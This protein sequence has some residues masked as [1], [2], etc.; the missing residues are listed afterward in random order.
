MNNDNSNKY[1]SNKQLVYRS[2]YVYSNNRCCTAIPRPEEN[3]RL[4]RSGRVKPV[5][6]PKTQAA[7]TAIKTHPR[8]KKQW[9]Q[10]K[11]LQT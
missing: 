10:L 3:T 2:N 5:G 8:A 7:L 9:Q 11:K 1:N 6:G 4:L